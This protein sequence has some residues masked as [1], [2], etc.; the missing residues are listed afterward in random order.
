M[1]RD[2]ASYVV[3]SVEAALARKPAVVAAAGN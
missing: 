1:T 3:A 2:D